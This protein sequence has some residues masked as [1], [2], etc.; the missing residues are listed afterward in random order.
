MYKMFIDDERFPVDDSFIIVR[1]SS[2]A[3]EYVMSHGI[4]SF[5]SFDHD[6]GEND[7]SIIF[8]NWLINHILDNEIIPTFEFY[9]HSQN[10]I[11]VE[12]IKGKLNPF[13][14]IYKKDQP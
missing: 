2:Q 13:L 10:P 6:L 11:G 1:N 9:V 8:I 7:T 4:P 12:N 5:I 3:I 14:N